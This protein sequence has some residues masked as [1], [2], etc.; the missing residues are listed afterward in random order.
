M[1]LPVQT[2]IR[3]A[4]EIFNQILLGEKVPLANHETSIARFLQHLFDHRYITQDS[5]FYVS[6]PRKPAVQGVTTHH[7]ITHRTRDE[8]T[9][10]H[11]AIENNDVKI[12]IIAPDIFAGKTTPDEIQAMIAP[13]GGIHT[14]QKLLELLATRN[15][16][17][18]VIIE[19]P[20]QGHAR[21]WE[22]LLNIIKSD[23]AWQNIYISNNREHT[24][25]LL[26]LV[27]LKK[28]VPN[29]ARPA[30][31][32][33][34]LHIRQIFFATSTLMKIEHF[35][36]NA[37][38]YGIRVDGLEALTNETFHDAP[39]ISQTYAGN[40]LEK[41]YETWMAIHAIG[42]REDIIKILRKNGFTEDLDQIVIAVEDSGLHFAEKNLFNPDDLKSP[43]C[44]INN[45]DLWQPDTAWPGVELTHFQ[46][47]SGG[48]DELYKAIN[49]RFDQLN[50]PGM[51]RRV[52]NNSTLGY[53]TLADLIDIPPMPKA[54]HPSLKSY[55]NRVAQ[56]AKRAGN[57]IHLF[58][59]MTTGYLAPHARP[60]TPEKNSENYIIPDGKIHTQAEMEQADEGSYITSPHHPRY[61]AFKT[62]GD[63]NQLDLS[64]QTS[65]YLPVT[66]YVVHSGQALFMPSADY[67][68]PLER[69]EN[70]LADHKAFLLLPRFANSQM[71]EQQIYSQNMFVFSSLVVAKQLSRRDGQKLVAL[72]GDEWKQLADFYSHN[73]NNGMVKDE[74][75]LIFRWFETEEK[76]RAWI[77]EKSAQGIHVYRNL[78][79]E[80]KR[81]KQ[82]PKINLL[83]DKHLISIFCSASSEVPHYNDYVYQ[84]VRKLG[85]EYGGNIC[86]V[87]GAS[88]KYMMGQVYQA[89]EDVR[90]DGYGAFLA[91]SSTPD[92]TKRETLHG[93]PLFGLND[94]YMAENIFQ[95]M[96]YLITHS[97]TIIVAPGGLGT[98]QELEALLL[99]KMMN[100]RNTVS[101]R[102][103]IP[104]L[105]LPGNPEKGF[106]D[107]R[108][109]FMSERDK[110]EMNI[111][112]IN[113]TN[114]DPVGATL[115]LM[116]GNIE[117]WGDRR[118][119]DARDTDRILKAS[120]ADPRGI[121]LHRLAVSVGHERYV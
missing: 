109:Q 53:I 19:N 97:H 72:V 24:L 58:T 87:Y 31:R 113:P 120:P 66:P 39:E 119:N 63:L 95:R 10:L 14:T 29:P 12:H 18:P 2:P 54:H 100:W 21:H 50:R 98:A 71:S 45:I 68:F 15:R 43:F 32:Q 7:P 74:G 42:S 93:R 73:F 117:E 75:S 36:R 102:V 90:R 4:L 44:N 76:A 27:A 46:N 114:S 103:I 111:D 55:K 78:T 91:G 89:V 6:T 1:T 30:T 41:L 110:K 25:E 82:H 37:R 70:I 62:L 80:K 83:K 101:T 56:F 105:N 22:Y 107:P 23:P 38:A 59:G 48:L 3:H 77:A 84:T 96:N 28:P 40:T 69:M 35:R 20:E 106:W 16:T 118:A 64:Q 33:P 9:S 5:A 57:K 17:I 67:A 99:L 60:N 115:S 52:I 88:D 116:R 86:F 121:P 108:L 112:V 11:Q 81:A 49:A 92:I 79:P 61:Q 65:L 104:N 8:I 26:D 51:D 94:F 13:P 34:P 47:A 85:E